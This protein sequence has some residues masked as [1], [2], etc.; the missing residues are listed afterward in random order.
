MSGVIQPAGTVTLVFT[1]IEGST[2]LL[3]ELGQVGYRDA[4][5][6]H[7]EVVRAAFGRYDE[8]S[9]VTPADAMPSIL[10]GKQLVVVGD[11]KQL[12]PSAFFVSE[13]PEEDEDIDDIELPATARPEGT[14]RP[15]IRSSSLPPLLPGGRRA[16][17][18]A[19]PL[20]GV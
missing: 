12:P 9:Q 18:A 13:S 15:A 1:D 6:E 10:R 5:A 20:A 14:P 3:A 16:S 4:L 17:G 8:A 7:R 19:T 2:R 11:E